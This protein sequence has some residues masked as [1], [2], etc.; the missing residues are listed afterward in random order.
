[1]IMVITQ[2][3]AVAEWNDSAGKFV[4]SNELASFL[5]LLHSVFARIGNDSFQNIIDE[6]ELNQYVVTAYEPDPT[7][8]GLLDGI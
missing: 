3:D 5:N 8:E 7:Q 4:G 2:G 1:M 6:A